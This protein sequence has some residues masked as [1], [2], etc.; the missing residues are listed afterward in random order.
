MYDSQFTLEMN[1]IEQLSY[2]DYLQVQQLLSLQKFQSPNKEH[3]ELLFIII[4][5]VY[6]LWFKQMIHELVGLKKDLLNQIH[7]KILLTLKRMRHILKVIGLQI[8]ILETMGPLSFLSFRNYLGSASGFQSFQFRELEFIF[9]FKNEKLLNNPIFTSDENNR[10][11]QRFDDT[12]IWQD[13]LAFFKIQVYKDKNFS[14]VENSELS[15]EQEILIHL[16]KNSSI[17][18]EISELIVDID[19]GLQEWRYRH[20]KMVERTIGGGKVGTGGSSGVE[21][22]KRSLFKSFCPELWEIRNYF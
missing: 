18:M 22:L 2:S 9:G 13:F 1:K 16:Y 6:E 21:Y 12:S 3:D 7:H 19:E 8:D 15:E 4:H 10:L 14:L 20:I 5:Q 11:K 17:L